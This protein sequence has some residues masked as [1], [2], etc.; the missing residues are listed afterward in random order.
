MLAKGGSGGKGGAGKGGKG[1]WGAR[2]P[3]AGERPAGE[4]PAGERPVAPPVEVAPP[5]RLEEP[6]TVPTTPAAPA[7]P[8]AVGK[9]KERR[10]AD[11]NAEEDDEDDGGYGNFNPAA[12]V[13]TPMNT[14]DLYLGTPDHQS[15]VAGSSTAEISSDLRGEN[16][17]DDF[18]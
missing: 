13:N 6:C 3:T 4:C 15:G 1:V 16:V 11:D 8:R 2:P 9:S 5:V 12:A 10:W 7:A 14:D 18:P 17:E